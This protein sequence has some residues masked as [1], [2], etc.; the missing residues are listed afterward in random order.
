[1]PKRKTI[2]KRSRTSRPALAAHL[3]DGFR[4]NASAPSHGSIPTA[5]PGKAFPIVGLGASAGGLEAL[6]EF[7]KQMPPDCGMAFVVVT[8]QH[9]GHISLLPELLRKCAAMPVVEASDNLRVKPNCV[10]MALPEGY[11]AMLHGKLHL[12]DCPDSSA[13]RLPIDYF[14]RS[15]AEDQRERAMG[16]ILSGTASD[17]TLG[18]KAIK[19]ATGMTMAQEPESAKYPGMPRSAIATGLVDYVLPAGQLPQQLAGLRQRP[20]PGAAG[21]GPRALSRAARADAENPRAAAQ[22]HGPR[23][24]R[25]QAHHHPPAHRTADEPPPA[26]RSAAISAVSCRTIRT[27]W[28]CCSRNC[29]SA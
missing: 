2:R 28:T 7:F 15:L 9:P 19:G 16:I 13:V 29:S 3:S 26:Q 14:F 21:A 22:P 1:M 8:H 18:V 24:L 20:V 6:E 5:F 23:F 25:L 10:Y 12:M 27:N 4:L 17:G 11:L